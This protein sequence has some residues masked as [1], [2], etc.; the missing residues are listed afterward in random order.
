MRLFL[1][2]CTGFIGSELLPKLVKLG[3][4]LTIIS[5]KEKIKLPPNIE[6]SKIKH[7]RIDP[8]DEKSWENLEINEALK[9]SD[10][11]INFAGEPIAEKRWTSAQMKRIKNSRLST[12][13]NLINA[14]IGCKKPPKVLI[15]ASAI[16]F[17]GT[18]PNEVYTEKSSPG[19]DFLANLCLEWEKIANKKP[20]ATRLVTLRIGIVLANNGGA[21]GKMLPVFRSGLGGPIGDGNQWMSW[22]HRT[23]LCLIIEKALKEK[24]W[25]GAINAVAPQPSL[26]S[27]FSLE[28]GKVLG[29]PSSVPVP[30]QIL[31]L[32]LGDGAKVVLEGQNVKSVRLSKLNF[33]FEYPQLAQALVS[34]TGSTKD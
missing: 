9:T 29:R 32:L 28:L 26:M 18:S 30:G 6:S 14:L 23:D 31:K 22:I 20:R 25:D 19:N 7:I 11:V 21:L 2:G 33:K 17:Y 34:I 4:E 24:K 12:T 1:L 15:N 5:R 3:Y 16:G 27:N 8:S 10:G 13:K